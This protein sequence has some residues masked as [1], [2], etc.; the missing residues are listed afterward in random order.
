MD[1][2]HG[3]L[4]MRRKRRHIILADGRVDVFIAECRGSTLDSRSGGIFDHF[5]G[6]CG[7]GGRRRRVEKGVICRVG[8]IR[9]GIVAPSSGSAHRVV[10]GVSM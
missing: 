7:Y 8:G 6:V 1:C 3:E 4:E 9:H 2:R 5:R 10:V